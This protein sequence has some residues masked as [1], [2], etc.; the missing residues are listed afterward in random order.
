M[1]YILLQI[2][3]GSASSN[4]DLMTAHRYAPSN[5]ASAYTVKKSFARSPNIGLR[6]LE[7][8]NPVSPEVLLS[9]VTATP[10]TVVLATP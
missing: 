4:T 7:N 6:L 10:E 9:S 8:H 2:K 5:D 1:F 3:A